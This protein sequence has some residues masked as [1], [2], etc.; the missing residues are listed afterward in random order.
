MYA[1]LQDPQM[2]NNTHK[3]THLHFINNHILPAC[4]FEIKFTVSLSAK[5]ASQAINFHPSL[6]FS[7]SESNRRYRPHNKLHNLCIFLGVMM[8]NT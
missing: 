6:K 5:S 4:N 3:S 8:E 2:Q 7:T 1:A